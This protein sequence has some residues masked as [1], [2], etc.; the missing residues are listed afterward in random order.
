[1]QDVPFSRTPDFYDYPD[2]PIAGVRI[3]DG[4]AV[5]DWPDGRSLRAHALWLYE[6][7]MG[8]VTIEERTR[9][10][11]HD[12]ADLPDPSA[13]TGC[14]I[15]ENGDLIA[16]WDGQAASTHHSGWLRHVAEGRYQARSGIPE[17]EQWFATDH[18][19]PATFDGARALVDDGELLRW[20]DAL[21]RFGLARLEGLPTDED[22]VGR[23]GRRIGALR[24][25]NFGVTWPVS[26]DIE[27]TSTANTTL[28]LPPH[29]DLPTREV[30]PGFQLLHCVVNTC[31]AGFSTM[32]DGYAVVEYLQQNEPE[33]YDALTTCNWLFFN[34]SP[35]HDHR[36][37]GPIIDHRAP[38]DPLTLRAFHPVRAFPDMPGADIPRAYDALRTFSRVAAS[39]DFQMR[40][41]FRPGDLVGFD[42]RRILHG[43]GEID[44]VGGVRELRG[45]YIDHDEVYSR[46][47][48]LTRRQPAGLAESA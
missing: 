19:A 28:P 45:T 21:C 8:D 36:W 26:V 24:E 18:A 33:V 4:F 31:Q 46:V 20:L 7:R 32:A 42:N 39:D 34:R 41:P 29:T 13:L 17:P 44:A 9:E 5:I 14:R 12:P 22:V 11:K 25:T 2:T 48:V 10:C 35:D 30:P 16:E 6:N 1:M 40:Y 37:S 43:R 23:I 3:E 47:R 27:P 15:A 38:G